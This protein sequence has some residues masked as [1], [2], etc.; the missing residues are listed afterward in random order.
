M[1][2]ILIIARSEYLRTVMTKSFVLG[3]LLMPAIYGGMFLFHIFF[4]DSVEIDDRRFAVID[5][6][7]EILHSLRQIRER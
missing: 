1:K 2:K 6:T 4:A 5:R 7:G 3:L